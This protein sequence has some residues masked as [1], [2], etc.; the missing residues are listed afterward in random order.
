MLFNLTFTFVK[1][2][3]EWFMGLHVIERS[4]L[5][6]HSN[7]QVV[8]DSNIVVG[9]LVLHYLERADKFV[10]LVPSKPTNL[11]AT[12]RQIRTKELGYCYKFLG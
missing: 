9:L 8:S 12:L 11:S 10:G 1:C 2:T 6:I 5:I 7:R 3:H 4:V